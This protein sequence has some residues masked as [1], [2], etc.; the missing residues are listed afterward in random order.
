MVVGPGQPA[1]DP[2]SGAERL[3]IDDRT[4]L[5]TILHVLRERAHRRV[6]SVLELHLDLDGAL[7]AVEERPPYSLGPGFSFDLE[8]LHHLVWSNSIDA[9]DPDRPVWPWQE[10]ALTLGATPATDADVTLPDGRPAWVDGGPVLFVE[11]VDGH[12]V[13]H[14]VSIEHGAL[15]PFGSNEAPPELAADQASAVTH[16][17]AGSRVIAPAGSGKTRV[18]TERAR[19]LRLGWQIPADALTLVAFN[20]R[21]QEEM[22]ERTLDVARLH[23]R[24]LNSLALAIVNGEAPFASTGPRR[25][26]IDE[27]QVRQ[28]ID[29]LIQFPKRRNVDPVAAWI[30]ALT[31]V[32]LGLATP[33]AVERSYGGDVDGFASMFPRYRDE[34]ARRGALDFDEQIYAALELVL[35]NPRAR[36]RAQAACRLLLVDELQDL[37][38]AH[39]LLLRLLAAP[40]AAVFGVGD[41]DQT[42]YGYNGADPSWLIDF[43]RW[44]PGAGSHSLE[45]NYRCP[46]GIVTAV[47]RLLRH[48]RR[49]VAKTIRAAH[50]GVQGWSYETVEAP[51]ATTVAFV[52]AELAAGRSPS[53]IAVLT[54]VNSLLAP[55]QVALAGR[56]VPVVGGVGPEFLSRTAVRAALA[57]LR[58]AADPRHLRPD[59]LAE[60]IRRPSRSVRPRIAEW[61]SEQSSPDGLR[62][63]AGRLREPRDATVIESFAADIDLLAGRARAGATTAALLDHLNHGVGLGRTIATLDHG[64]HGMN[65]AAQGDDLDALAALATLQPDP[66]HVPPVAA[67]G[68]ATPRHRPGR[69]HPRHRAP[70]EGTGVARGRGPPRRRPA[71]PPSPVGGR[72][73]GAPGLPRGTHEGEGAGHRRGDHHAH[74]VP[75]RAARRPAR[76]APRG[77]EAGG[78]P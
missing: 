77:D 72:R 57:W 78:G 53:D 47:D 3:V 46:E 70:R 75:R 34:L 73:G 69:H 68:A 49:R 29:G 19:L 71:V 55:V 41:D 37:T 60:A 59:D 50:H 11:Q 65:R 5:A 20:K 33:E 66:G 30:E 13:V 22:R 39:V 40:D 15:I 76:P 74:A 16:V 35:T 51:L 28:I 6:R 9:R 4:E 36:H 58:M 17:S 38:P 56:G 42:I 62:Q 64:R 18:L 24:T 10:E 44:F 26:T 23:V 2:W 54:R 8:A 43:D 25:T 21:A 45:V 32:R 12:P 7:D 61:A 27:G 63:L 14:R 52:D 48:N 67:R 1:P 31:A